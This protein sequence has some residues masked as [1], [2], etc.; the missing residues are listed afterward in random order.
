MFLLI[1][2]IPTVA[3]Q[4]RRF[5]FHY[6]STY[7]I[8]FFMRHTVTHIYIPL[9]FYLYQL[10][11]NCSYDSLGFT[12]HYVSTYT[13]GGLGQGRTPLL[14]Y[15]PL[16]FYLYCIRVFRHCIFVIIYI[17]LCFYLYLIT[18]CVALTI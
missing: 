4:R 10:S 14:I 15:I 11:I 18:A 6:V 16:C 7:T 3:L 9:C 2:V 12:F 1:Q 13:P 8:C 5:T 17:P